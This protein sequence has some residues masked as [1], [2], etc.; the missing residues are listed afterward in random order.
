MSKLFI[1][2]QVQVIMLVVW[3][4]SDYSIVPVVWIL[5]DAH[6]AS[7]LMSHVHLEYEQQQRQQRHET[8]TIVIQL[9]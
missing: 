8:N 4:S 3:R 1:V 6:A 9:L 7:V 5:K 2:I